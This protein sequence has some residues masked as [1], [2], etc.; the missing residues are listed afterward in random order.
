MSTRCGCCWT[1]VSDPR[2][3]ATAW[4]RVVDRTP[5]LRSAV[6]WDG[7]TEPL[8]VVHRQVERPH[9]PLRLA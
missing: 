2:A 8:Q 5:A 6:V 9:E 7:V 3:L 4:Q 1:G